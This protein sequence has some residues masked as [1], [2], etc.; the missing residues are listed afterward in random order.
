[1]SLR[2]V[3]LEDKYAKLH[4]DVIMSGIQALVRLPMLQRELD[5]KKGL[6]TAGFISGY[7]GSPLGGYDLALW[8]AAKYLKENHIVFRP[9][10]NEDLAAT[11][12]WGSQQTCLHKDTMKYDGTFGIWYGKGPGVDRSC[13]AFK[14]ANA[15][16]TDP[17]GGVLL[18]MGDD[19]GCKSSTLPHQSEQALISCYIPILNPAGVQDI[20]EMGLFGIALSRYSG[21]WVGFKTITETVDS[22]ANFEIDLAHYN[23]KTPTDFNMPEDGTNIRWPEVP[24]EQEAR[25]FDTKLPAALAFARA[26]HIDKTII[27]A[28]KKKIGIITTGKSYLD[29]RQAFD[30]LNLSLDDLSKAGVSLY[31]VGMTWPLEPQNISEFA[32]ENDIVMVI[33][34]KQSL[35]ESQLKDILYDLPEKKRPIIIGKTDLNGKPLFEPKGELTP[36][37]IAIEF[38]KICEAQKIKL[39]LKQAHHDLENMAFKPQSDFVPTIRKPYYCSGCPHNTSTKVP[40]GSRALAGI[41]CHYMTIWMPERR[42]ETYTQMGGEGVPWIGQ[43]DFTK[44]KHIFANLGD[45]TYYHSGLMAIRAAAASEVNITYK[46]LYNDAVAMTGG[47]PV[48]GPLSVE[49]IASQCY[50]EGAKEIYVLSDTI[51]QYDARKFD[52]PVKLHDRDDLMMVQDELKKIKG[53]S[54]LIYE[55]TCAAEKRRRRKRGK[56]EDPKKRVIINQEVC[57]G[58]GDCSFKSNC[59]SVTPVETEYGRKRKIDQ[60]SCNKDYSCLKGFCPSFVTV[61]GGELKKP[62][63]KQLT[64]EDF[65]FVP[66]PTLPILNNQAWSILVTGVGGTGV[67]T[68]GALLGM[69]AHLEGKA[70][71]VIDQAGLAQKGGA[72]TTHL[73]IAKSHDHIYAAR[74]STGEAD[75]LLGCDTVVAASENAL[76]CLRARHSQAVLNTDITMT[77]DF[78]QNPEF[79]IPEDDLIQQIIKRCDGENY[80]SPFAATHIAGKLIGDTVETNMMML[81]FAYQKGLIPVS[82]EA[83]FKAIE[84]NNV[85]IEKNKLAFMVGRA[86]AHDLKFVEKKIKDFDANLDLDYHRK[87]E[88]LD[89]MIMRRYDELIAY[90]DES[91]AHKYINF[92]RKVRDADDRIH[93]K[94]NLFTEAVAKN[95]F[96]LLAY[97]D[98]YEVAR[99]YTNGNFKKQLERT[100]QGKYRIE[101]NLA[102]PLIAQ[103]DKFTGHLKK[104]TYGPWMMGMFKILAKLKFLR[105]GIFDIFGYSAERKMERQLFKDYE[106]MINSMLNYL[107]Q[108]NYEIA[109]ELAESPQ[110]MRGFGHVKEANVATVQKEQGVMLKDFFAQNPK[111]SSYVYQSEKVPA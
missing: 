7:R 24:M 45:G 14:H 99:L 101:F 105:G 49:E 30:R 71:S 57:E 97:K 76:D 110:L 98:E 94:S 39:D 19:H 73:K 50:H 65:D 74:L 32:T 28:D 72:V 35:I 25:I 51:A 46:I 67:V 8:K 47:Q 12:V 100:F 83:I 38:A 20:I 23:F 87:S 80:V 13:D 43:S 41:G 2:E 48:D 6:N 63:P 55:Q 56:M 75:L 68:I 91:L 11:A 70:C 61:Y 26:N 77:A 42:T 15:A 88:T 44:D 31:K 21:L 9:G 95:Y 111:H 86:S 33:E 104:V 93:S 34:E 60:F 27:K 106:I 18:M 66:E 109:V 52:V 3:S 102:P 85:A 1:M 58:C 108:G 53:T 81:G 92:V 16:G 22:S 82:N 79:T 96:K 69:A 84:L 89:D 59:L 62:D 5:L 37:Q 29:V 103:K 17:N 54:I 4:G 64:L 90:Q 10:V 40:E 107:I 36:W 78:T